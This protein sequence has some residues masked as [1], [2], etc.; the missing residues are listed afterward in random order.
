MRRR[1]PRRRA[2]GAMQLS[3]RGQAVALVL[4]G[5]ALGAA[6]YQILK[7]KKT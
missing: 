5:V 6:T 1:R 2:L 3:E 4:A 7:G